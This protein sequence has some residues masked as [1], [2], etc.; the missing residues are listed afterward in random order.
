[1][2]LQPVLR[3]AATLAA[4][5]V[6]TPLA[7][8]Q[9]APAA[10]QASASRATPL[11]TQVR[12]DVID[13]IAAQLVRHYIVADT[14][15]MIGDHLKKRLAAGAY[16]AITNPLQFAE[17]VGEDMRAVNGDRHLFVGYDPERP[18]LRPGPEG[19]RMLG[20]GPGDG[21]GSPPPQVVAAQR[22]THFALGKVDVL[23]GNVGYFEIR[24]FSGVPEAREAVVSALEYLRYTDA[25]IFDLRRN[26]GGSAEL[27]NF[28]LSHFTG[29]DTLASLTVKNR[30]G[31]ES[32]TR[33]TLATVPGPRRP[34][35]P[36]F[37]LTS[38]FTASAGEDFAFVLAH[39][40]RATL[41]GETTAGAGRNNAVL[42]VGHGF[43]ASI[44]FS[45]VTDPKTGA[46][47]ERVGVKPD[48]MV[49]QARALDVAHAQAL[50]RIA[51]TERD[52]ERRR[53]LELVKES[54]EAQAS[55]R[56]IS[57]AVLA[58]Y[59]GR[60]EG[61]R[62]LTVVN[63]ELRYAPRPGAPS[64]TL[65]PLNDTTFALGATRYTFERQG[66]RVRVKAQFPDG[67]S[68]T[69]GMVER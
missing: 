64:E 57:P 30:S 27:V 10:R 50:G 56:R 40:G 69:W 15:R 20:P 28:V 21:D 63:G 51:A 35:V 8:Q 24:G 6:A 66:G 11:T 23:P 18:G 19:I 54:V 46:E 67:E 14:G 53:V 62:S 47:W 2:R 16:D 68:L 17:V 25:M 36:V 45:R 34:D 42:D 58:S 59:V 55:P 33:Y 5:V 32:F 4:F 65:V 9:P 7:A 3:H 41:V 60:Y 26:G 49:D 61:G 13:S 12:R 44:S 52:G 1:M 38:G 39:L 48:V 43:G 29:P 37:V 22:R 31:N